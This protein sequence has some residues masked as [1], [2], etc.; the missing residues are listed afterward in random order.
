MDLSNKKDRTVL[1]S[2]FKKNSIPTESNFADLID[3]MLNQKDDGIA[4]LPDN[5]LSISAGN[6][7]KKNI[8]SLYS[9]LEDDL[10]KWSITLEHPDSSAEGLSINDS[11]GKSRLFIDSEGGDVSIG[12]D[13]KFGSQKRQ[14]INLWGAS[15]GI[16][17]QSYT[18]YFRSNSDFC[19][20]ID[21]SHH[22]DKGIPGTGGKRLMTLNKAGDLILS[23]RTNPE[24]DSNKPLC[25]AL[26]DYGEELVINYKNDF[27]KGTRIDGNLKV[28]GINVHR[29]ERLDNHLEADGAFYRYDGQVY[30][31][32]DDNLYIRD[33]KR[34]GRPGGIKFHFDT[35]NGILVQEE[36]KNPSLKNGWVAYSGTYNTPGYFKDSLG[37]VHLKGLVKAGTNE[38]IFSLPVGYRPVR[39]ELQITCTRKNGGSRSDYIDYGRVDIKSTGEVLMIKGTK[40]WFSL[41]GITFRAK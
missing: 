18:L 1:K 20:H 32:V 11:N 22:D 30:I 4:K 40:E 29:K 34:E 37:I 7:Q 2:F 21:G 17:I 25:R 6:S 16:G 10:P 24:A 23:A 8:L 27:S 12:G 19:W 14:M 9:S 41:D 13:L 15:Y 3:G 36:W 39:R 38:H 26:V 33:Q 5:P 35:R 28:T 31:T